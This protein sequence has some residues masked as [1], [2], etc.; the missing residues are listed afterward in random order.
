MS[1]DPPS[2]APWPGQD[3]A[4]VASTSIGALP[5][6]ATPD[7]S[8]VM[9]IWQ[10]DETPRTRAVTLGQIQDAF[11]TGP[12]GPTGQAGGPTGATGPG[13][14]GPTGA[15][16]TGPTGPGSPVPIACDYIGSD[17][18]NYLPGDFG[19]GLSTTVLGTTGA[20]VAIAQLD[21]TVVDATYIVP[22]N[23]LNLVVDFT[24]ACA[25]TIPQA[26][27]GGALLA[28]WNCF[29]V[30]QSVGDV[31]FT[32]TVS[33][34][35]GSTDPITITAGETL[36][37]RTS[38]GV[39]YKALLGSISIGPT[40]TTGPSGPSGPTGPGATG[41]TGIA[42]T[43]PTGP[44][45]A[46]GAAGA[47]GPTGTAGAAGV[48]GPTGDAG[49]V[50]ATGATGAAGAA[51]VTG[52]T[53]AAGAAG[54][55]GA[56]GP[57]GAAGAAGATGPTGAAGAAGATGPTGATGAAGAAG[58]TGPTGTNRSAARLQAQ[59]VTG[60]VVAND[61]VYLAYDAPF[62]GTINTLTYFTANGSFTVAIKINGTNVTSLSAVAVSSATPATATATG[63]NT[64]SAGA[65]ITAVITAATSSPTDAL[66]SLAL[67]WS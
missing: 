20:S 5:Q 1:D 53:G 54:A 24:V 63:A 11:A 23:D 59:W 16:F 35:N 37:L 55:A 31:V 44:A 2:N 43:G 32:A 22:N 64:F 34:L 62:G 27:Q 14:T 42:V 45:G 40:G 3:P 33:L 10:V 18:V 21:R 38:D 57:T 12:T 66:L 56:T 49:A 7:A 19:A 30:N 50:G 67:T 25:V 48:T 46:A 15:G 61:T 8:N 17:G 51:G 9:P 36:W 58:A 65:I 6:A 13:A 26:G 60:A 29:Y 28:G 39:D 47:T 41:A 52:P 4:G